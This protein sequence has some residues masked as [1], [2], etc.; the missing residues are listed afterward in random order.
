MYCND[1]GLVHEL[2][3]S[4]VDEKYPDYENVI[5]KGPLHTVTI[6]QAM[7]LK[8]N[9]TIKHIHKT[10]KA[11]KW[12]FNPSIILMFNESCITLSYEDDYTSIKESFALSS[13]VTSLGSEPMRVGFNPEYLASSSIIFSSSPR[14]S[15]AS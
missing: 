7:A 6:S 3:L 13:T 1:R 8:F 5:P 12:D 15:K 2:Y 14:W 9:E 4:T 10:R 11:P